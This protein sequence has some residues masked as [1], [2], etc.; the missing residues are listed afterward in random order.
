MGYYLQR[1]QQFGR[2]D[3]YSN[4]SVPRHNC[5]VVRLDPFFV[6]KY[7]E[8]PLAELFNN[9]RQPDSVLQCVAAVRI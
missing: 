7:V 3:E 9:K 8:A 6:V 1:D 2:G 4:T 5:K